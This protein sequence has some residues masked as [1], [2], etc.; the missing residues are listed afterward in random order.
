MG[1]AE[2]R[3]GAFP[4]A[5]FRHL[6]AC[7]TEVAPCARRYAIGTEP[8]LVAVTARNR[9]EV[10][11]VTARLAANAVGMRFAASFHPKLARV[12]RRLPLDVPAAQTTRDIG[13][14]AEAMGLVRPSYACVREHV[15]AERLRRA[16]RGAAVH[17]AATLSLTR[18]IAPTIE[19][20]EAEYRREV[21]RRLR[22]D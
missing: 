3:L 6:G 7:P 14:A 2:G 8:A 1:P 19:A 15:A 20:V 5:L 12:L 10:G 22:P 9:H 11:A 21:R 18:A 17:V 13:R 16:E 4:R